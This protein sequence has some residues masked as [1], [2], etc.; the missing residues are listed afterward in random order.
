MLDARPHTTGVENALR[1][2]TFV[3]TVGQSGER[4]RLRHEDVDLC[5]N[6]RLRANERGVAA[7]RRHGRLHK[8]RARIIRARQCRPNQAASPIVE[9][10]GAG[11]RDKRSTD[12]DA[13]RRR[14]GNSPNIM[15]ADWTARR[16]RHHIADGGSFRGE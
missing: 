2:E 11:F 4:C 16:K 15:A 13:A 1:V 7:G 3:H 9:D 8:R 6:R 12:F 5:P 10:F 14:R